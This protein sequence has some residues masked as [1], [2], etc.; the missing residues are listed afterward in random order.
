MMLT[1]GEHLFQIASLEPNLLVTLFTEEQLSISKSIK[2]NS[3]GNVWHIDA[4][5]TVVKASDGRPIYYYAVVEPM[6]EKGMPALPLFEFVTN[7]HNVG[8]IKTALVS[9]WSH[10]SAFYLTPQ[11]I[12]M[13]FSWALMHSV[14]FA[15][16]LGSLN[17]VIARQWNYLRDGTLTGSQPMIRLCCSHFIKAAS[18]RLSKMK[19]SS[20]VNTFFRFFLF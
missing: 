7:S 17:D 9:W 8:N 1:I 19:V 16:S 11:T 14:S 6:S 15:M 5:G 10:M 12:V 20:K 3:V 18:R 2:S 4:T 13:D